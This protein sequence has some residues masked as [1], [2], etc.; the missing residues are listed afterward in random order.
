MTPTRFNSPEETVL[1]FALPGV[2]EANLSIQLAENIITIRAERS[3]TL[4]PE[5][6][7]CEHLCAVT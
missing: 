7:S 5:Q 6:L 1:R 2:A 4:T 3:L